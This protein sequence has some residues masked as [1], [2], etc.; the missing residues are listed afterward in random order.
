MYFLS[1]ILPSNMNLEHG[2]GQQEDRSIQLF[3][4]HL[5]LLLF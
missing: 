4:E 1:L 5:A 3:E 2:G